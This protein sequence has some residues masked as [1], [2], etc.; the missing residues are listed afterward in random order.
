ML[1]GPKS[2]AVRNVLVLIAA[3]PLLAIAVVRLF[4]LDRGWPLIPLVAFTPQFAAAL[5]VLFAVAVAVRAR[6]AA[7][8]I[9]LMCVAL[10]VAILPRALGGADDNAGAGRSFT[11][12]SANAK[13]GDV[14]INP[15]VRLIERTQP[16]VIALQ[17]ATPW[18]LEELRK[19]GVTR[20]YRFSVG[21]TAWGALGYLTLSRTPLREITGSGL[22]GGEAGE[23]SWPEMRVTGTPVLLRNVH[24]APPLTPAA[25]ARWRRVL[26]S[27]P[28]PRGRM[29]IIAG[30]FNATL[31]HRDLRAVLDRGYRDAGEL[32]GNGLQSTWSV[33]PVR[34]LVLDHVLIPPQVGVDVY[35]VLD[36]PGSD[37]K[38]I[39]VTLR[40]PR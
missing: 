27:L 9:G 33:G 23:E 34:R 25:T 28:A 1:F 36:L 10:A 4:G 7:I 38:A 18:V 17:E 39:A 3:S 13:T 8:T 19:A 40:L 35:R 16:E 29:R 24:P 26:S 22:P 11:V 14:Q 5:L 37:H 20:R 6:W 15:L 32:S 31:D 12:L 2:S 30:D 21:R